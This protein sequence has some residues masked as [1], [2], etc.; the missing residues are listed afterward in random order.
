MIAELGRFLIALALAGSLAQV[1]LAWR[2][3]DA[4]SGTGWRSSA[5]NAV[6][7]SLT[8]AYLAF[9]LL[10]ISFVRSD[11]SIAYV[12]ANSHIDKPWIYKIAAAWGGH[13]GSMLLWCVMLVG[14]GYAISTR[15]PKDLKLRMRAIS[16]QGGLQVLFFAFLAIASNPFDRLNP[17][18][19][20]GNGLNPILQD[21]A[22]ALHPPLLYLG[23]V[24]LSSTFA[25][26]AAGRA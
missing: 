26:A 13:E 21:P 22:L 2:A 23:Y 1:Y 25:I 15:G 19:I 5:N 9:M 18:P 7:G 24:G 4:P 12:A 14:F 11:F 16:F 3:A 8:A 10:I 20:Q 6:L 17:V